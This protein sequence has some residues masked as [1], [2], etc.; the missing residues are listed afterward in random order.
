MKIS[1][2][3]QDEL[4]NPLV[5]LLTAILL[6]LPGCAGFP[7]SGTIGGQAIETRVDSEVARYYLANYLPGRHTDPVLDQRI[8]RLYEQANDRL[9]DR[10]DLKKLS[11]DF[12]VD[13]AALYLADQ[14]ARVPAN[15]R[16]QTAFRQAYEYAREA[17]PRGQMQVAGAA[18]YDVLIVPTYL[19]KRFAFLTGADMAVPRAALQKVGF[20]CYFVETVDDGPVESNAEIIMAA[21][22]AR[23]T[24]GR[25]LI[26]VSASKSGAEVALA[27]T[28]LGPAN[29]HHVAA[30]INAVG[31]LQGTPMVDDRLLPD[32][33]FLL[34]KIDPAGGESMATARSR[35]RFDSFNI[36]R[37]VL[38]VN[39]FGIPTI[40][41][42]S[43][44]GRKVYFA[45]RKYGPNDGVLLLSDMIF[46]SGVTLARLG[47]DHMHMNDHLDVATV[48]LA[49]TMIEWLQNHDQISPTP[50]TD[51]AGHPAESSVGAGR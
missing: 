13:F 51:V 37:T 30:W 11:D 2:Y 15:A 43:F 46:P 18:D 5:P 39:Y 8:D 33:E 44:F 41:N 48:A 6:M 28:R 25:R 35:Q 14:I 12:S 38:V 7:V 4:A 9:P 20:T 32:F 19:Y 23:A 40:G 10:K 17:F 29:T 34:G 36:P 3:V 16:F 27:L 24:S 42:I 1:C 50:D 47:S 26:V 31:A 21:I 49:M 22:R 45:L